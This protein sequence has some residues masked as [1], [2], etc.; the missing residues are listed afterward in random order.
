MS[1][2]VDDVLTKVFAL[3]E[4]DE[5]HEALAILQPMLKDNENNADVWWL[6]AHAVSDAGE[7]QRALNKVSSID[8]TYPGA[9]TLKVSLEKR[10]PDFAA[11]TGG[12]RPLAGHT[13]SPTIPDTLPDLPGEHDDLGADS[14]DWAVDDW[15]DTSDIDFEGVDTLPSKKRRR[16]IIPFA[17]IVIV[18]LIVALVAIIGLGGTPQAKPTPTAAVQAQAPTKTLVP[19]MTVVPTDEVPVQQGDFTTLHSALAD[20]NVPEDGIEIVE[21]SLGNTLSITA[22][23]DRNAL[24]EIMDISVREGLT[25]ASDVEAIGVRIGDCKVESSMRTVGVLI[26]DVIE[27]V[28]ENLTEQDFQR[29]WQPIG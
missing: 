12:I 16:L 4:N 14:D 11:S 18:I 28:N 22:C 3:I 15:D 5:Q 7:A 21:T 1:S 6:Y 20:F 24:A 27:Y 25:A 10:F 23:E 17:I 8:P 19:T 29:L 2:A 26:T 9:A 13:P